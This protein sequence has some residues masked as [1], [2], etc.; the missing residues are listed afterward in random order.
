MAWR[1]FFILVP[2]KRAQ[3]II[4]A[5]SLRLQLDRGL[6]SPDWTREGEH[7]THT[8]S[9]EIV[10]LSQGQERR[11]ERRESLWRPKH[12]E[13]SVARGWISMAH[14]R[15]G[16]RDCP[17][18]MWDA[19]WDGLFCG[20][21]LFAWWVGE[22]VIGRDTE[23]PWRWMSYFSVQEALNVFL[24]ELSGEKA[25]NKMAQIPFLIQI[26]VLAARQFFL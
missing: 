14:G 4:L 26:K 19:G 22:G 25:Q 18:E 24:F 9:A 1:S 16:K 17:M 21:T 20:T 10:W 8:H 15:G 5:L 23:M 7:S 3:S 6:D 2:E 13:R 11:A 12:R